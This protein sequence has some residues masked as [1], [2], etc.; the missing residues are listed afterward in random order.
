MSRWKPEPLPERLWRRVTKTAEGCWIW[1]GAIGGTGYGFIGL[2]SREAGIEQ[3]HRVSFRMHFGEIPEHLEVCHVCDVRPCVRPEH[4]FLGTR[5][6]NMMDASRKG[7]LHGN[8]LRGERHPNAKL[9]SALVAQI[10]DRLAAGRSQASI[11]REL[12]ITRS[13][14]WSIAHNRSWVSA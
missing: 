12:G 1:T 2:G 5:H 6:D 3:V 8:G 14:V 7:R 9:T 13:P 10:R 11:A 4:L